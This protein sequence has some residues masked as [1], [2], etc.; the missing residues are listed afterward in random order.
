MICLN[1]YF[2]LLRLSSKIKY[3]N[4]DKLNEELL[5]ACVH[6]FF[7][8]LRDPNARLPNGHHLPSLFNFKP[9]VWHITLSKL[10]TDY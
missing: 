1:I 3:D 7:D 8:Q 2:W 6:P 4:L 9:Q 5:E 10:L